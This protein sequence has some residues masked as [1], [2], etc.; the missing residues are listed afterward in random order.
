MRKGNITE[1]EIV[2]FANKC[3][4]KRRT[5]GIGKEPT[6]LNEHLPNSKPLSIPSHPGN[7]SIGTISNILDYLEKDLFDIEEIIDKQ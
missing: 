5:G 3:G 1:K 7:I 6:Y 4:R 2:R